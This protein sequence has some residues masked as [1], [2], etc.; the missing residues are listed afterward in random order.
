MHILSSPYKEIDHLLDLETLPIHYQLLAKS[1]T[2][3]RGL[4]DYASQPY[5]N[6][7]NIE[8]VIDDFKNNA[9]VSGIKIPQFTVYIVVFR[10]ILHKEIQE[11]E[12][13]RAVLYQID[14][15]AHR[16]ANISGGLLKYW[17]GSPDAYGK[18]LATCWWVSKKHAK[19]GGG[20]EKHRNGVKLVRSWYKLWKIEEYEISFPKY[21]FTKLSGV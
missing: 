12:E 1:L 16:E 21:T 3:F 18:N 14:K 17:Y 10:S 4:E 13:H 11:S 7:F 8:E 5:E 6:S 9:A 20:G 15:D 2:K 19:L